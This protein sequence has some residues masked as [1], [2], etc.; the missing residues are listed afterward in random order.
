MTNQIAIDSVLEFLLLQ[1]NKMT[2]NMSGREFGFYF[3]IIDYPWRNEV[4]TGTQQGSILEAGADAVAMEGCC[5]Q[6]CSA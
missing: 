6:S 2:K 3:Q 1:Q 4:R 5:L